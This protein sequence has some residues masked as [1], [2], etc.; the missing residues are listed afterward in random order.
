M[1]RSAEWSLFTRPARACFKS[2]CSLFSA[3]LPFVIIYAAAFISTSPWWRFSLSSCR[4][5][6]CRLPSLPARC[7][8]EPVQ[9]IPNQSMPPQ[10]LRGFTDLHNHA[11]IVLVC[12]ISLILSPSWLSF[13]QKQLGLIL[14]KWDILVVLFCWYHRVRAPACSPYQFRLERHCATTTPLWHSDVYM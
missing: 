6:P 1:S 11:R 2:I 13:I 9:P 8:A 5:C 10:K 12:T 3:A 7:Q 14:Y 4:A